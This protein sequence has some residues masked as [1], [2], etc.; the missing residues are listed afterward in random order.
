VSKDGLTHKYI[1]LTAL[2]KQNRLRKK[3]W[4]RLLE[5]YTDKD[6][7]INLAKLVLLLD[8]QIYRNSLV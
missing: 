4:S 7:I 5:M 8:R 6:G 1:R 3:A 2:S